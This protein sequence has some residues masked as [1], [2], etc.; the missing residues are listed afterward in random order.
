MR[1]H[2]IALC[3]YQDLY[4]GDDADNVCDV[5]LVLLGICMTLSDEDTPEHLNDKI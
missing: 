2:L 4:G 5:D 1:H 3:R